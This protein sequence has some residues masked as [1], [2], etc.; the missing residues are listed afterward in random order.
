MIKRFVL[1]ELTKF[2]ITN[3][4]IPGGFFGEIRISINKDGQINAID[5]NHKKLLEVV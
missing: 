5:L 4:I 3:G 2:L 1:N